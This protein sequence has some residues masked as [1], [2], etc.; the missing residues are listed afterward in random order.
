M[1]PI[2]ILHIMSK[3][4]VGGVENQLMSVLSKYDIQKFSPVVCSLSDRGDIGKEIEEYGI[5]VTCLNKLGHR[6]DWTIV[7][8]LYR[9][10]RQKDIKIV[11]THQ[12]HANLYGRL[13]AR[14]AGVPCIVASV[15][16]I[17]T[18]DKKRHRRII[19]RLLARYTDRVV[20]V[21]ET[22]KEDI[23]RYDSIAEDK[24][25]VICNGVNIR[26]FE[27][28][29]KAPVQ[30]ELGIPSGDPVVGTIGRLTTQKG[31]KYLLE[32]VTRLKTVYP[33]L[34][35][36]MIGD[37]PLKDE[38]VKYARAREVH[39][40]VKFL[41]TR[42]DIPE[43]LSIM[44]IFVLPSLWEGLGNALIEAMA[45]GKPIITT[46][47]RPIREVVDSEKVGIL[48]PVKDSEA[49]A[50]AVEMLLKDKSLAKNLGEAAR[51]K[52][53]LSF[54]LE[55]TVK[56]YENLFEEILREKAWNM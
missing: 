8:D 48:V 29:E 7:K 43:L 34:V 24:I 9:L 42:R 40:N 35:L 38:L 27:F 1:Q 2:P 47:I 41:G 16:N 51:K 21:S 45:N 3:L 50:S 12:Y 15:H 26:R 37:G 36:L 53:I 6:F 54:N 33:R 13:A 5:E 39:K 10:I 25:K 11:R 18:R 52:V 32:A 23:L 56:S 55:D 44:D 49:I 46:D 17:Y 14:L 4:P 31:Q 20:A 22:V 30:S 28:L 19:N